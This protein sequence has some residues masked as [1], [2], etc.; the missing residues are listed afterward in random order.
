MPMA[1]D[2]HYVI[3]DDVMVHFEKD[4]L[5]NDQFY[6]S[7]FMRREP[8]RSLFIVFI[9]VTLV[10]AKF[11]GLT[12]L[13]GM[14]LSFVVI[15]TYVLPRILA[16]APP[17]RVAIIGSMIIIP[18][19]FFLSHGVN[20]KTIVAMSGTACSLGITG[21]LASTFVTSARL[22]GYASEE[23]SFIQL[24]SQGTLNMKGLLLAGIIIGVLGVL[25]DITISQS[26]IVFQLKEVNKK[27]RFKELYRRAISVGQDHIASM[28]NTL[29]LVYTGASLP[30]LLLFV[31][32]PHPFTEIIN[33]EIIADEIIRT[34]VGSIGLVLAVPITTLIAAI[35]ASVDLDETV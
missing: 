7:D 24:A 22:T 34:L 1:N 15:F 21:F 19:S 14:G 10:V 30:L 5:G 11:R 27:M 18:I 17:V 20:K 23:S 26:A 32:S 35:V 13:L 2:Q 16:G 6:I 29:V 28:V 12:S 4:T 31:H 8:L 33:Y 3:G 25:D 9:V